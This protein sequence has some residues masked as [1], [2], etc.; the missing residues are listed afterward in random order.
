MQKGLKLIR[1]AFDKNYGD[2]RLERRRHRRYRFGSFVE[3]R[4][5]AP[6]GIKYSAVGNG[7]DISLFGMGVEVSA[8]I[9]VGTQV[10]IR[11]DGMELSSK[12]TIKYSRQNRFG[13]RVG[14]EFAASLVS[15]SLVDVNEGFQALQ[16]HALAARDGQT[17]QRA[18]SWSSGFFGFLR[19]V[20]CFVAPHVLEWRSQDSKR[21][22]L[23]CS[24]CGCNVNIYAAHG[25]SFL[26]SEISRS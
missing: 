11:I 4:W 22:M 17:R 26:A 13:V 2:S 21:A 6:D 12:A 14:M 7:L 16:E 5:I 8:A 23:A 18:G 20:T 3:I 25:A 15:E 1:S 10:S 9:P 19:R 24:R